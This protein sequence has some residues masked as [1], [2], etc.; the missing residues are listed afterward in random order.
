MKEGAGDDL[1]SGGT[2]DVDEADEDDAESVDPDI[3]SE[4]TRS[5]KDVL[6]GETDDESIPYLLRRNQVK[7]HRKTVGFGLQK[8]TRDLEDDVLREVKADLEIENLPATDLREAAY[9]AGLQNQERIKQI[10]LEWG[11]EHRR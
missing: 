4:T 2:D 7:D 10:L 3:L 9:L 6:A 5:S 8:K 11:Y 1:L